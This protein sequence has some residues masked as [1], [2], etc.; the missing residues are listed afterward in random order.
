MLLECLTHRLRGHY[1]GD[2]AHYREAIQK[3]EWQ[4]KDPILRFQRRGLEEGRIAEGDIEAAER[5]AAQAVE[6]AVEFARA[7]PFPPEAILAELTY[8][9]GA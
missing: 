4:E 9:E 7:S 3:E 6:E 1:E 5:D 8:A 2:P